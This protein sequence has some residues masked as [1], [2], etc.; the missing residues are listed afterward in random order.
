MPHP[1]AQVEIDHSVGYS[2]AMNKTTRFDTREH[3]LNTGEQLCV[4]S[5]FNGTGLIELL[6][7]AEV[8]KGSFYYY[9]PSKEAFGVAML[10]RYF[11]RYV[12]NL[13]AFLAEHQGDARQRVLEYYQQSCSWWQEHQFAGCLSVKLSAEVCDLSEE[14]RNALAAG[15][16]ALIGELTSALE[17][18]Q[19]QE[20]LSPAVSASSTAETLYMLWLGASLQC[21]IRRDSAPLQIAVQQMTRILQAI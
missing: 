17:K 5:G 3:I 20:K 6:K 7:K 10:E 19:Q 15:S 8:P 4:Q 9:F 2:A 12:Q 1:S 21:K 14:M 13:S 11:A 16:A 18:A